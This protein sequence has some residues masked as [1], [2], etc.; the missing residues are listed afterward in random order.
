MKKTLTVFLSVLLT[1]GVF[2]CSYV[3]GATYTGSPAVHKTASGSSNGV[4]W[5][6]DLDQYYP[7]QTAESGVAS[8]ETY[9]QVYYRITN[10]NE[11]AV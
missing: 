1:V 4:T 2:F 9:L 8:G 7:V 3:Y 6:I 5:E 10:S 11:Q